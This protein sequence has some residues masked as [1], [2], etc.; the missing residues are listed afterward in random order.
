[1]G[2]R[3]TLTGWI[4]SGS[5]AD[6][7][8]CETDLTNI[9]QGKTSG[10][11]SYNSN[12]EEDGMFG[13]MMQSIQATDYREKRVMIAAFLKTENVRRGALWFQVDDAL[14]EPLQFD[15]MADR[16]LIGDK[17]WTYCSCILDVPNDA[18]SIHFGVLIEGTGVIWINSFTCHE[19]E[20]TVPST[21]VL[22]QEI[23]PLHPTNLSFNVRS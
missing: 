7:Y 4:L 10:K 20:S 3:N 19:V 2:E 17:E 23:L 8:K 22:K 6:A 5:H 11:L 1:M 14:G 12:I 9:Y 13:T 15:N 21:N 18:V 16:S